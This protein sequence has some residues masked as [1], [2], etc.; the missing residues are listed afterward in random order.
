MNAT[1]HTHG[2]VVWRELF[3]DD[4]Q[5]AKGFY[6]EMFGWVFKDMPM[7]PNEPPYPIA[8]VGGKGIGGIA[9]KPPGAPGPSF[10]L[11]YVSVPDVDAALAKAQAGG[12]AAAFGPFD[13][14]EVGR[15]AALS[16]FAGAVIGLIHSVNGDQPAAMPGLGEFCWETIS[17]PD[18]E[19]ARSFYRSVFGWTEQGMGGVTVFGTGPRPED[20][21]ADL[22]LADGMP[23]SW[24][25]YVVVET[26]ETA[27]A[28]AER[29]GA[30]SVVPLIEIPNV[31]RIAFVQ[32]P[33][34]A[35]VGLFQP[36]R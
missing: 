29:L 28:R 9:H 11:S 22:Q 31:G 35:H 8:Q 13:V 25:T 33:T 1:T 15:I 16:D 23:P 14:P 30:T 3:T 5:R 17:S 32:D 21:V 2:R 12:G 34:G 19:R 27:R 26:I 7:G 24:A 6:G 36:A 4:V 20:G 10:W 18:L